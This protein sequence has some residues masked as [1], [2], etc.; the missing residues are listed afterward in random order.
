MFTYFFPDATERGV[1]KPI[2]FH[3]NEPLEDREIEERMLRYGATSCEITPNSA[4]AGRLQSEV[5]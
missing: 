5:R 2:R 1:A 3:S 4:G